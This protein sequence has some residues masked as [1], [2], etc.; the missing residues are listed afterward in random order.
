MNR[1]VGSRITHLCLVRH[2]E[3]L[4]N[5]EGRVQGQLDPDLS[6]L[7]ERQAKALAAR[8]SREPW[9]RLYASDLRRALATAEAIA[10]RT[11]LEVHRLVE[12][13]ERHMGRLE[14]LLA[15]EARALYPDWDDP[16][17]GRESLAAF[18]E[19][20]VAVCR[21][22]IT[23]HP[24]E[25]LLVVTHGGL[26]KQYLNHLNFGDWLI[27]NTGIT[28]LEWTE[29]GGIPLRCRLICVNDTGHIDLDE[30]LSVTT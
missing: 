24:G 4:W 21:R 23:A 27:D 20:A 19:R 9:D 5:A 14:G 7:G 13:R 3:S 18:T 10:R 17:V 29:E 6:P 2:G 12:L 30:A 8:L 25:R 28:R 15:G 22:L 16:V 26:I 1:Q 11:G